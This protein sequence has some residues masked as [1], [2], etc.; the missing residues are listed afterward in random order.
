MDVRRAPAVGHGPDG[1]EAVAPRSIGRDLAETLEGRIGAAAVARVVVVAGFVALPDLD[2][3]AGERPAIE[4]ADAA[5]EPGRL[6]APVVE[7]AVLEQIAIAVA[8]QGDGIERPLGLRGCRDPGRGGLGPRAEPERGRRDQRRGDGAPRKILRMGGGRVRHGHGSP[9]VAAEF[10]HA[11]KVYQR[12]RM[13]IAP[14]IE[15]LT[16][17]SSLRLKSRPISP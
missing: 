6:A 13:P 15:E 8:R 3:G 17:V 12:T 11:P 4:I 10:R 2:H 14:W 5:L 16:S 9:G 1:A 7:R